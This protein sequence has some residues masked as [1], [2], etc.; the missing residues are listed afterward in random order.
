MINWHIRGEISCVYRVSTR[1]GC[2]NKKEKYNVTG[3]RWDYPELTWMWSNKYSWSLTGRF[4]FCDDGSTDAHQKNKYLVINL[5]LRI[6]NLNQHRGIAMTMASG[7]Q[8]EI[9][10][11]PWFTVTV[12]VLLDFVVFCR[13]MQAVVSRRSKD[14]IASKLSSSRSSLARGSGRL[15]TGDVTCTD[16]IQ[17]F[18]ECT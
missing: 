2:P 5:H 9:L 17:C 10:H 14:T 11:H 3:K 12:T 15:L 18:L 7:A 13:P 16:V 8:N 4:L 6:E 1:I